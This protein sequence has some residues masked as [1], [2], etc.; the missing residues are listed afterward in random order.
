MPAESTVP[1]CSR[2]GCEQPAATRIEWRNPRIHDVER[3]K[4][5]LACE[6]HLDFLLGFLSNRDFPVRTSS[7]HDPVNEAPIQ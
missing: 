1:A 3:I 2:A 6:E 7:V 4:I 5:W